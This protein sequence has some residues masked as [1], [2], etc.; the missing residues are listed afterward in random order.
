[1]TTLA[2]ALLI[3]AAD[4]MPRN[5]TLPDESIYVV[6]RRA[7]VKRGSVELTPFFFMTMSNKFSSSLGP[8]LALV[9]HP[10][11]NLALEI[12]SSV[13]GVMR[14]AYSSL[15]Y[16]LND[17]ERLAPEPVDLKELRYFGAVSL[18]FS[19]LYGKFD[20]YGH[21]IDYDIYG[22]AGPAIATT[23]EPCAPA[24]QGDCGPDNEAL[25][26]GLRSPVDS[27]DRYKIA[28]SLAGGLRLFFADWIGLRIELR[29]LVYADRA[30]EGA[31]NTTDIRNNI[32]LI[33]G[34]SFLL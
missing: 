24:G 9:Y 7:Y 1:M 22:S 17:V 19:A 5:L 16:E 20:F 2:L 8:G 29:D 14:S 6:Q 18:Q 25:G 13:P 32:M 10:R 12:S 34:L 21:L 3:A 4:D 23:V 31:A 15:I 11:E 27:A 33:G 26:R 28:A 30:G